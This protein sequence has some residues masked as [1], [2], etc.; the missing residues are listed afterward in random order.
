MI[1]IS[2]KTPPL[3]LLFLTNCCTRARF[4][5]CFQATFDECK[6]IMRTFGIPVNHLPFSID[7][8]E[9]RPLGSHAKWINKRRQ[10]E[11]ELIIRPFSSRQHDQAPTTTT[12]MMLLGTPSSTSSSTTYN[13]SDLLIP[14]CFD[15][16]DLP[17]RHDVCLGRGNTL[18]QH[19]GNVAM[20]SMMEPLVEEYEKAASSRR[21]E[22]NSIMVKAIHLIGGNFL[23][24]KASDG[25][26]FEVIH[27]ESVVE[28][29]IGGIFRSMV[30]RVNA[31][32]P[33]PMRQSPPSESK[34]AQMGGT[35]GKSMDDN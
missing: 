5:L 25:G 1:I 15:V 14:S 11:T 19:S 2:W 28:K 34:I 23:S 17:G 18:H 35:F 31:A 21:Q 16:I 8:S 12:T 26:W 4:D 32:A 29:S 20:R 9:I 33:A 7:G 24:N 22:L 3:L 30:S 6:Q 10:K 13:H 27:D